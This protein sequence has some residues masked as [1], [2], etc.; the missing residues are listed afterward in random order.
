MS[1]AGAPSGRPAIL[2]SLTSRLE[3]GRA[4]RIAMQPPLK[5]IAALRRAGVTVPGAPE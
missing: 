1:A 4:P 5:M 2:S 3:T